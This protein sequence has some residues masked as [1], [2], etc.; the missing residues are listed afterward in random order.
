LT[1]PAPFGGKGAGT[2]AGGKG[3]VAVVVVEVVVI[4]EEGAEAAVGS[5]FLPDRREY[6]AAVI[7]APLPAPRAT[8]TAED[9]D[10]VG[11]RLF[12]TG[13]ANKL[14]G[15]PKL[16]MN[17]AGHVRNDC[18]VSGWCSTVDHVRKRVEGKTVAR[19]DAS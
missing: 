2:A 12:L 18:D 7:A 15:G 6:I 10:M 1:R 17:D 16:Y 3:C 11:Y 4:V 8:R 13:I 14:P 5:D 9:L 19:E